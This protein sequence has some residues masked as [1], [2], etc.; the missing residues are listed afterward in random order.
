MMTLKH[1]TRESV[2]FFFSSRRRHTICLSDWSSDVCSSDL[3]VFAGGAFRYAGA[4][5]ADYVARW[6]GSAWAPLGSGLN[7]RVYALAVSGDNLFVGG[8]F[9]RAAGQYANRVARWHIPSNTWYA[10]G[11][12]VS[13]GDSYVTALAVN[14]SNL[15]VGGD[16]TTAGG[17]AAHNIARWNTITNAWYPLG[18]GT[19]D[20]VWA[21]AVDAQNAIL[22]GGM[23][24]HA[25]GQLAEFVARWSG[26][27]W[28]ALGGGEAQ[29]WG[30]R[31]LAV[32][33]SDVYAGG[34]FS[35]IGGLATYN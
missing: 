10:L 18:S 28:S 32:N 25:G 14:G 31:T 7:G 26:G 17:Q 12:G 24:I 35:Q 34:R 16:F 22:A 5:A 6:D 30:V 9:T 19:D 29:G 20:A 11:S 15:Y 21:L 2:F 13:G 4:V 33:G 1:K 23:F 27:S 3:T 8:T